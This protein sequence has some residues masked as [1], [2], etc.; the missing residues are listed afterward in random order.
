MQN[1][2]ALMR[3]AAGMSQRVFASS[4]SVTQPTVARWETGAVQMTS[5]SIRRASLV[6]DCTPNDILGMYGSED[7]VEHFREPLSRLLTQAL[8]L[9]GS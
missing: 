5:S 3:Q 1:N 4:M 8:R 6:L 9:I 2:L 7:A